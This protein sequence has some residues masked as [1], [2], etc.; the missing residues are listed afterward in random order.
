MLMR[1]EVFNPFTASA[2]YRRPRPIAAPPGGR[3]EGSADRPTG[4]ETLMD[5][6][7]HLKRDVPPPSPERMAAGKARLLALAEQRRRERDMDLAG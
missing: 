6:L 2:R 3:R 4:E 7:R 5:A 1:Q